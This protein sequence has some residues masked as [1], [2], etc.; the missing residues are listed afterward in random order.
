MAILLRTT[1]PLFT[2]IFA[3]LLMVALTLVVFG[4]A[5]AAAHALAERL[6]ARGDF[7]GLAFACAA[8]AAPLTLIAG[9]LVSGPSPL[10][11]LL[12]PVALY[13]LA[14]MVLAVRAVY[15]LDWRATLAASLPGAALLALLPLAAVAG[16]WAGLAGW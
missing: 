1:T 10:R 11:L 3:Y 5:I 13:A 15:D 2:V 7:G 8:F 14:L 6:G 12:L 9:L 4:A 16:V